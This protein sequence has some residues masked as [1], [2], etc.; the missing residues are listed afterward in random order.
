MGGLLEAGGVVVAD[1][2]LAST[3]AFLDFR[4]GVMLLSSSQGAVHGI[5]YQTG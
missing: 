3:V 1:S 4:L 5:T 2:C